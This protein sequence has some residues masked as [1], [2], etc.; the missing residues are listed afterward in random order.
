MPS[1]FKG[2]YERDFECILVDKV[3]D[4]CLKKVCFDDIKVEIPKGVDPNCCEVEVKFQSGMIV[5]GSLKILESNLLPEGCKRIKMIVSINYII[6]VTCKGGCFEIPGTLPDITLDIVMYHPDTR[7]EFSFDI[8]VETRGEVLDQSVEEDCSSQ[9]A[10]LI[11]AIG[12]FV[13][14]KVIGKVQLKLDQVYPYC[15][16]PRD[17]K[18][19][20][21]VSPCDDF[22]DFEFPGDFYPEQAQYI[23]PC[24]E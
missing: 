7:S 5:P 22:D 1:D 13:I 3:F 19:F 8:I 17:C 16:P 20:E 12:V 15:V 23:N 2:L 18:N 10:V 21:D 6:Q 9:C 24:V 4:S 11:L 14:P